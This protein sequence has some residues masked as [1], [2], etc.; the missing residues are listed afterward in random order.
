MKKW[1]ISLLAA[2]MMLGLC[3]YAGAESS[4]EYW[5][6]D[7]KY[8]ILEDGTVAI[9]RCNVNELGLV[10]PDTLGGRTV[11]QID[12]FSFSSSCMTVTIPDTVVRIDSNP[13]TSCGKLISINVSDQHP[14]FYTIGGALFTKGEDRLVAYPMGM[15]NNRYEVPAGTKVIGNYAFFG[16]D[17]LTEVT[18]PEG[19]TEVGK[20]AFSCCNALKSAELPSSVTTIGDGAFWESDALRNVNIPYGVTTIGDETFY[21][22][23]IQS[24]TIPD[25]VTHIGSAAFES[26]NGLI[27]VTIPNSVLTMGDNPFALCEDGLEIIVA[28]DHPTLKMIDGV[29]YSMPDK[30]LVWF[31]INTERKV[32]IAPDWV[33]KIDN[34]VFWSCD[35][36]VLISL[37]QGV[38]SI[39]SHAFQ[40]CEHLAFLNIPDTVT[41]MGQQVCDFCDDLK[42]LVVPASVKSIGSSL[43]HRSD[44]IL[45]VEKGSYAEKY[46]EE[47][48]LVAYYAK[49][50]FK[51]QN[52]L[53]FY[54][55]EGAYLDKYQYLIEL[56]G[57]RKMDTS[58]FSYEEPEDVLQFDYMIS[59]SPEKGKVEQMTAFIY[60]EEDLVKTACAICALTQSWGDLSIESTQQVIR[61]LISGEKNLTF[62][63]FVVEFIT[64][65]SDYLGILMM[66]RK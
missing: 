24:I 10:I 3:S 30:R 51:G 55:N 40:Q 17:Y 52:I 57:I 33:E 54:T 8:M 1:L 22:T 21:G 36:I 66:T 25:T 19:V 41:T 11:T 38:K 2:A 58:Y 20:S 59:A 4:R 53:G 9:T 26:C 43:V 13:F 39:G 63:D 46:A 32:Y 5:D 65:D 45:F 7:Y 37:P 6:G 61:Q 62:G 60:D 44:T 35:D 31:P 48:W 64:E 50:Y 23:D 15:K 42:R 49:D 14:A 18:I 29:L 47:E 12:L 34:A 27:T 56:Y 28:E 16:N